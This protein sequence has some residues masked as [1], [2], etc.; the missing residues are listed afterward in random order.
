MLFKQRT[1]HCLAC[2]EMFL[3]NTLLGSGKCYECFVQEDE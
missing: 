1:E 3:E 2:E